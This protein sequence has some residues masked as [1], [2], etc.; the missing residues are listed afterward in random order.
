MRHLLN[1]CGCVGGRWYNSTNKMQMPNTKGKLMNLDEFKAHVLATR[2]NSTQTAIS[3]ILLA[4]DYISQDDLFDQDDL[5]YLD[6][7]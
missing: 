1:P 3:T 5:R 6:G 7:E 4:K 2:K